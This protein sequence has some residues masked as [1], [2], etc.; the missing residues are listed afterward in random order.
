MNVV[1]FSPFFKCS[2]L[3]TWCCFSAATDPINNDA[4]IKLAGI[5]EIM[6]EPRKVLDLV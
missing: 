6:G 3:Y 4:K 1:D 5:Y 2:I